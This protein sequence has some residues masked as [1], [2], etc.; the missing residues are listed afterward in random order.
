MRGWWFWIVAVGAFLLW[1]GELDIEGT[2]RDL[3]LILAACLVATPIAVYFAVS[4]GLPEDVGM[5]PADY[6]EVP[7]EL[8]PLI[9]SFEAL[10]FRR[11]L[12]PYRFA[13]PNAPLLVPLMHAD[14][15]L[16]ATVFGIPGTKPRIGYDV[17]SFFDAKDCGLTT[18]MDPGAGVLPAEAGTLRQI[19]VNAPPEELVYYHREAVRL[20]ESRGLQPLAVS[21]GAIPELIRRSFRLNRRAFLRARVSNT[22]V[23]IWRVITKRNPWIGSLAEQ[24]DLQD[25]LGRIKR[26][27]PA[28][29]RSMARA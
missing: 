9:G 18:G 20:L 4:R 21:P 28:R 2:V 6:T 11:I 22:L 5:H 26:P 24:P 1:P 7:R 23:A 25:Q 12:S 13:L 8:D 17:V 16:F 15:G 14:E 10:G 27:R 3:T 29:R 19:L